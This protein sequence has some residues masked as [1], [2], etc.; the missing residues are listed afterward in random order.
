MINIIKKCDS[1]G[2]IHTWVRPPRSR[3]ENECGTRLK[4]RAWLTDWGVAFLSNKRSANGIHTEIQNKNA[5]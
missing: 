1:V 3:S 4:A 2:G 5:D